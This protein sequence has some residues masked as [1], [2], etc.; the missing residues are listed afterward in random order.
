MSEAKWKSDELRKLLEFAWQAHYRCQECVASQARAMPASC[1]DVTH[2]VM[3]GDALYPLFSLFLSFRLSFSL[4]FLVFFNFF[5]WFFSI[6]FL[7]VTPGLLPF[8]FF[9]VFSVLFLFL[10][11]LFFTFLSKPLPSLLWLKVWM[12]HEALNRFVIY[13]WES[14]VLFNYPYWG[15]LWNILAAHS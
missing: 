11:H 5:P 6:L 8:L 9:D 7:A 15:H 12:L 13:S 4:Y 14:V 3:T 10:F 1:S 2:D